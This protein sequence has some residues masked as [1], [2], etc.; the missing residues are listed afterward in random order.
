MGFDLEQYRL[1]REALHERANLLE[2]APHLSRPLPIMLP[3]Y[4][5]WQVPY[6]WC[7]IKLYDFVSGKKLVKSSFYVSKAK[8]M[9][10]FPMLQKNRLCGALVYYD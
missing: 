5:W 6:F 1:V 8:A 9:E 3:I 2:I 7:G 10:E 4:S